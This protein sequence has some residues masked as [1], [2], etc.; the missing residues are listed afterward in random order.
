MAASPASPAHILGR[1][2]I[3]T[4]ASLQALPDRGAHALHLL[5]SSP[6]SEHCFRDDGSRA[7]LTAEGGPFLE[8]K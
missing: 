5:S 6:P 2:R 8:L 4:E 7:I 3:L 1:G